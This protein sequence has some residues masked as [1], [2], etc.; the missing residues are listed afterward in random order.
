MVSLKDVAQDC[1]GLSGTISV[2]SDVFGY[3]FRDATG[4]IF[5]PLGGTDILPGTNTPRNRSLRSHLELIEG[6]SVNLSIILVGHENDFSGAVSVNEALSVQYAIQVMRDIYGQ[7]DIG[8]RRI[9]WRRIPMADVGNYLIITDSAEAENLTDDW[10]ANDNDGIDVFWV[11][12]ILNASGWCNKD[13]PCDKDSKDGL[14]G[15]VIELLGTSRI[16][17]IVLAHEVGHYLGLGSGPGI[18]NVMGSDA[19]GDGIDTIGNT[20][21]GLTNAQG[22]TMKTHCFIRAA[23]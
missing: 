2:N 18:N 1:L 19:D 6:Q 4:S 22:N 15:A 9:F 7:R 13:G 5:G 11:Q 20:S 23:C 12:N 21:T 10:S 16:R 17:G 3:I 14:T 8:V